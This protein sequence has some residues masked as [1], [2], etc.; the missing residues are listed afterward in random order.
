M[1]EESMLIKGIVNRDKEHIEL[2]YGDAHKLE[3]EE[4]ISVALVAPGPGKGFTVQYT[5][6]T[7]DADA[8]MMV[9]EVQEELEYYLV[10]KREPKPWLYARYHCGTGANWY[11]RV[12]WCYS[13]NR[14]IV[15]GVPQK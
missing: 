2:V 13:P 7:D 10:E 9:K 4:F 1:K 6:V 8:R 15:E 5:L 3:P 11:S 14:R 12:H